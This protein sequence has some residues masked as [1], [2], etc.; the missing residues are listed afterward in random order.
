MGQQDIRTYDIGT[1]FSLDLKSRSVEVDYGLPRV[2]L[3]SIPSYNL[4][5]LTSPELSRNFYVCAQSHSDMTLHL[6]LRVFWGIE[7]E[8]TSYSKLHDQNFRPKLIG[9][10]PGRFHSKFLAMDSI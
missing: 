1:M 10:W 4:F 9:I 2:L 6:M 8:S 5:I 3:S 7:L